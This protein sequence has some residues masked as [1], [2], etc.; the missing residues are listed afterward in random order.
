MRKDG[1][2]DIKTQEAVC[3]ESISGA[4]GDFSSLQR[5][6]ADGTGQ[7]G[8]PNAKESHTMRRP[9]NGKRGD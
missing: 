7:F 8:V 2:P 4:Y 5:G 3:S 6:I 9:P 1:T